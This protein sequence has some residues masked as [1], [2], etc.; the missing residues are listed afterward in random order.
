MELTATSHDPRIARSTGGRRLPF[1]QVIDILDL[2][3]CADAVVVAPEVGLAVRHEDRLVL[4]VAECRDREVPPLS[5]KERRDEHHDG[6]RDL[7]KTPPTVADPAERAA[8]GETGPVQRV[9]L[10]L[11][12]VVGRAV[13]LG[14]TVAGGTVADGS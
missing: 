14:A 6:D 11:G 5:E 2:R 9:G 10:A 8:S 12:V 3:V 1:L 13:A 4:S 7:A